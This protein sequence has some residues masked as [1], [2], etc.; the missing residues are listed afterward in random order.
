MEA[1]NMI[2]QKECRSVWSQYG[3]AA[4]D[5]ETVSSQDSCVT[6]HPRV[7]RDGEFDYDLEDIMVMDA[8]WLLVDMRARIRVNKG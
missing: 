4:E 3:S 8:I 7:N 6:S 2:R 1:K 5:E